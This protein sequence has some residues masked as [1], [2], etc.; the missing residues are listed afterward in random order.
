MAS[1][2]EKID[3]TATVSSWYFKNN[4]FSSWDYLNKVS[5][6]CFFVSAPSLC[7]R[8][9]NI[10]TS[11]AGQHVLNTCKYLV[12]FGE[13]IKSAKIY[14]KICAIIFR[15]QSNSPLHFKNTNLLL[16]LSC[17]LSTWYCLIEM[18]LEQTAEHVWGGREKH[19][20]LP[21]DCI[22]YWFRFWWENKYWSQI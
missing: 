7:Y 6:S 3:L 14:S 1:L 20:R 21:R 16:S 15:M 10:C 2:R 9:L 5:S 17:S 18:T 4:S 8:S 11:T 19:S 12:A 22:F 13:S